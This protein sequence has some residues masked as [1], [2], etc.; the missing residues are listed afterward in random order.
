LDGFEELSAPLKDPTSHDKPLK[1][2]RV[3][4][5]GNMIQARVP[6][7]F[8]ELVRALL[9]FRCVCARARVWTSMHTYKHTRTITTIT[10]NH[11]QACSHTKQHTQTHAN[12]H[13]YIYV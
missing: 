3:R 2:S 8:T 13:F 11:A 1:F 4:K 6:S 7:K 10:Q 12:T 9:L 5:E